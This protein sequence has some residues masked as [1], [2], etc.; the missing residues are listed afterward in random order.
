MGVKPGYLEDTEKNGVVP[1]LIDHYSEALEEII[2]TS[3]T[4]GDTPSGDQGTH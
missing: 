4:E 3:N 2:S 1:G